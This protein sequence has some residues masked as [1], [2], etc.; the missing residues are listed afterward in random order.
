MLKWKDIKKWR[1]PTRYDKQTN[2]N[3]KS[4]QIWAFKYL[5]TLAFIQDNLLTFYIFY[6]MN[7]D[8]FCVFLCFSVHYP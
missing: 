6:I 5:P 7:S 1:C 3:N 4:F 2:N 8:I